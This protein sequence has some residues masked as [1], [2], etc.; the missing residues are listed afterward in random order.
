MR[1]DA[2]YEVGLE[3]DLGPFLPNV[4]MFANP[5]PH[6]DWLAFDRAFDDGSLGTG[7][8]QMQNGRWLCWR[9]SP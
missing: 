7:K 4:S 8:V 3:S 2:W 6:E 9:V 1:A 5:R